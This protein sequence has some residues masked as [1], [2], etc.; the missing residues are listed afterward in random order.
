MAARAPPQVAIPK[1][2]FGGALS[3]SDW[4]INFALNC[5]SI[6][7]PPGVLVYR[8]DAIH[9][10]LDAAAAYFLSS[11]VQL[12]ATKAGGTTLVLP[13]VMSWFRRDFGRGTTAD[14]VRAV[15]RYAAID[16]AALSSD[17]VMVR[18]APFEFRCAALRL[19]DE[20]GRL[21]DA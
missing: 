10:Q 8:A 20:T 14:C 19:V 2:R 13:R 18:F 16:A 6:S 5:G 9:A 12:L 1:A 17:A 4:R 3:T 7:N 11:T 21:V 15:A